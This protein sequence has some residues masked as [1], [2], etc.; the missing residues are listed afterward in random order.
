MVTHLPACLVL[1]RSYALDTKLHLLCSWIW[2]MRFEFCSQA[3]SPEVRGW[4]GSGSFQYVLRISQKQPQICIRLW[5]TGWHMQCRQAAL[6]SLILILLIWDLLGRPKHLFMDTKDNDSWLKFLA[7]EVF[8]VETS[9]FPFSKT[10]FLAKISF[11]CRHFPKPAGFFWYNLS[12]SLL[13]LFKL[14]S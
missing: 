2:F 8:Y 4:K 6:T 9:P 1:F 10:K 13:N 3:L 5:M 12:V 7:W 11:Y 14:L